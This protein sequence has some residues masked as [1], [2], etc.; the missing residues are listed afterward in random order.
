MFGS[1]ECH[2]I[3]RKKYPSPANLDARHLARSGQLAQVVSAA[4]QRLRSFFDAEK[5]FLWRD[6]Q[7]HWARSCPTWARFFGMGDH[8]TKL[9]FVTQSPITVTPPLVNISNFT[10]RGGFSSSGL[11]QKTSPDIA[12][13]FCESLISPSPLLW[14]SQRTRMRNAPAPKTSSLLHG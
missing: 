4:L 11:R 14:Q 9:L 1:Q 7:R 8:A 12:G 2:Q 10:P 5:S 6:N 3:R 13:M